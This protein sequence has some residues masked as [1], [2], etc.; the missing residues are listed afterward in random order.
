M[1]NRYITIYMFGLLMVSATIFNGCKKS[2]LS[3]TPTTA[4]DANDAFT[5]PGKVEAAMV[6]L[7]NLHASGRYMN[8]MLL[9]ADIKGEDIFVRE[10]GNY[11]RFAQAYSYAE[12][13]TSIQQAFWEAGYQL[14]ANCNQAIQKIPLAPLTD[15]DKKKYLAEARAIRGST[16]FNLI[17]CYG[18]PYTLD[19]TAPGVPKSELPLN[20]DSETLARA[21]VKDIYDFI[22][23]DL[24][25]AE[26]NMSAS[27]TKISRLTLPAVQ[28]LLS[29]VY[30]SMGDKW[31]EASKFA[32]L[33]RTGHPL[34]DNATLLNGFYKASGEWI[35]D[36]EYTAD[37]NP[38]FV[39]AASF[40][41]PY[42]IG[43]STFRAD[44]NFHALFGA[45]DIR[46]QQFLI[47]DAG[48]DDPLLRDEEVEDA[49]GFLMNKFYF[50][51]GFDASVVL[52]RS[53]EMFLNE[54]EAEAELGNSGPAQ[55]ALFEVQRRSIPGAVIS[56]NTGDALKSEIQI[57]RRKELYGEGFRI[58]DILRRKETLK[59]TSTSHWHKVN[60]APGDNKF[61]MPIPV[62]EINA[63]PKI[64]QNP[65]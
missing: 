35:W 25:F 3:P 15:A 8:A 14:I 50:K 19:P 11:G 29:R 38:G 37:N 59:R 60:M 64:T 61:L 17:R 34:D 27:L 55:A 56:T 47:S 42:D 31:V 40:H 20:A 2:D 18:K 63:N 46:K 5:S 4:I 39:G 1:K 41:E 22:L 12:I 33:A 53:A 9:Q 26:Q 65:R 6:G 13:P 23:A 54:A 30:L 45:D 16:Y 49:G 48:Y 57:E 21:S 10:S 43:Y 44:I 32:K 36:M 58:F 28:G 7:Y 62:E 52:M 51:D 24:N